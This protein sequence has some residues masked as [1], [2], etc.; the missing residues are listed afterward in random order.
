MT[1]W[2]FHHK[3]VR[4][5]KELQ[6]IFNEKWVPMMKK[7]REKFFDTEILM[8]KVDD[9]ENALGN[10]VTTFFKEIGI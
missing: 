10:M 5:H 8:K 9:K 6:E 1:E 4:A 3:E 7:Y 2:T